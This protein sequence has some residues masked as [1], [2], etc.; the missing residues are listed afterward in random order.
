[1]KIAIQ[2]QHQ[3]NYGAHDWD[4]VGGCPQYWKFKGGSTYVIINLAMGEVI[5]GGA[6]ALVEKVRELIETDDNGFKESIINWSVLGSSEPDP[7]EEWETA[8]H[9]LR[10]T[11]KFMA[12]RK[13]ICEWSKKAST[14]SYVMQPNGGRKDYKHVLSDLV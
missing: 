7:V 8:Y 14:E 5:D 3:E 1:M 12:I 10:G 11:D 2:T 4:G 6:D 9:I 13:K